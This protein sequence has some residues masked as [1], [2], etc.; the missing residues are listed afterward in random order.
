MTTSHGKTGPLTDTAA[1][2][3]DLGLPVDDDYSTLDPA[4]LLDAWQ[5]DGAIWYAHACCSAGSDGSSIYEGLLE[6]GSWADQVLTGIAG[7][8]AH[9]APLPEA[10]LG[11]PRP[12][13]AFIGHVEPTFD[14]TIQNPYNG[15]KLTSSIRT[16]LYDGLFRPAAVGLA[17]RETYAHVGELFAERDSAYR[18]FDDG[19]DTAGVAMATT[20]AARDRQSMVVLGDPTVGLPPLP[21]RA[22]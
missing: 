5:P 19:E 21:S 13:R 11:A 16:G 4:R 14:W 3:R 2:L 12:L 15:Q 6:P 18:A 9:V 7:I 20:L 1:T 17:L 22:G 10:L 8:G